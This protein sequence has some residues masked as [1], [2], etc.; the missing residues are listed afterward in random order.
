MPVW[1]LHMEALESIAI[2]PCGPTDR[3]PWLELPQII[4]SRGRETHWCPADASR[5]MQRTIGLDIQSCL[6]MSV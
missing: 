4:L 3:W 1:L 5:E 6:D 2:R